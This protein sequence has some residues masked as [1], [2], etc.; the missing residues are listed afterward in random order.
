MLVE[1]L[2][3][4][5]SPVR[6][7]IV[8]TGPDDLR[9]LALA[10]TP[11]SRRFFARSVI[12]AAVRKARAVL[13]VSEAVR[14]ELE[15]RFR[16]PRVFVVPNAGDHLRVLPRASAPGAALLHVGHLEPRKSPKPQAFKP[17]YRQPPPRIRAAFCRAACASAVRPCSCRI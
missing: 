9:A 8:G 4:T 5:K 14:A 17:P 6:A 3:R 1:A 11:F 10:H 13:T 2:A 16:A 7:S 12:G 15:T